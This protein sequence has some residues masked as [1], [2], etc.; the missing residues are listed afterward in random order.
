MERILSIESAKYQSFLRTISVLR[1][2]CNDIDLRKSMIRQRT[3]DNSSIFEIDVSS[4]FGQQDVNLPLVSIK[5]KIELLKVFQGDNPVDFILK[6]HNFQV[7]DMFSLLS[8]SH[9]DLD[10]IDNKFIAKEELNNLFSL[11][12]ENLVLSCTISQTIA[13][14]MKIISS[15]FNVNTF[16]ISFSGEIAKITSMTQAKDQSAIFIDNIQCNQILGVG[17]SSLIVTPFVIDHDNEL[18]FEMYA[19]DRGLF[20]NKFSTTIDTINIVIYSRSA[21]NSD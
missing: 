12:E 3:N 1:D 9:A 2:I 15:A 14:R 5:Q 7:K 17:I 18:I 20:I 11:S 6:E 8:F 21:F 4:I 16:T 13:N 10:F 19:L